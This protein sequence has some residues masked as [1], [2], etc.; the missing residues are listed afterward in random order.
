MFAFKIIDQMFQPFAYL[1]DK[2]TEELAHKKQL[3]IFYYQVN[4]VVSQS[5]YV[6]MYLQLNTRA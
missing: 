6:H 2:L 1:E 4:I 3:I 5:F